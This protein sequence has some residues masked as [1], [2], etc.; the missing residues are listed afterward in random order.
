MPVNPVNVGDD[1]FAPNAYRVLL[2]A[3]RSPERTNV[4][5]GVV[6]RQLQRS[7]ERFATGTPRAGLDALLGGLLLVREGEYRR[8]LIDGGAPALSQ[9]A[10]EVARLGQDGYAAALY[11]MLATQLP[12]GP[13]RAQVE[14]HLRAI[15]DFGRAT[16]S[17]GSIQ[18]AATAARVSVQRALLEATP[19]ALNAGR[20]RLVTWIRRALEASSSEQPP[21]TNVERDEAFETYRALRGGT[22]ALVALYIRHGDP[23][24]VLTAIDEA[25][26]DRMIPPE[27]RNYLERAAEHEPEAW[28]ALYRVFQQASES[29]GS[30]AVIDPELMGAAAFGAAIELFRIQPSSLDAAMP[31]SI[32][33]I[34]YGMAEVA[35]LV[36]SGAVNRSSPPEHVSAALETVLR[37]IVAEDSVGQTDAARR[38]FAAAEK[39]MALGESSAFAGRVTPGPARLRYVMAA[40]ETRHAELGRALPLLRSA[41]AAEPTAEAYSMIASIERQQRHTD[42]ALE[43]LDRVIALSRKENDAGSEADA[44][45]QRFEVLRDEGRLDDAAKALDVALVRV[46]EA[47]RA[48]HPG[49]TQARVER[50]L[51]RVLEHYGEQAAIHRATLRA[52]EA[53][54]GDVRQV[55]ATVLDVSRRSLTLGDL[56]S[57]RSAAQR[58]LA[59]GLPPEEIVYVALWLQ[60]LERRLNVP[61]DGTVEEAYATIDEASGWPSKLRAWGRGKL[62]DRDLVNAAQDASQRTE[63]AFYVAMNQPNVP[64]KNALRDV[65]ASSAIELMEVTIARDLVAAR[66]QYKLPPA[67]AVP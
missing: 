62:T 55:A 15:D 38:T 13:E 44:L 41:V 48:G 60:L 58:A 8:E 17:G 30:I 1:D 34:K 6:R 40:I 45:V 25:D 51:A 29:N 54:D 5:I 12:Q 39:L 31:L 20:D 14:G 9:S 56:Q 67:V 46:I 32:E 43:A 21:R 50:L 3:A 7:R 59:A 49:P 23:Q 47:Q 42:A 53:S 63:A 35:S 61:S 65:A 33:L 19:E 4:L 57:A 18:V 11:S 24:G 52:F 36:V 64:P 66:R 16:Q 27:L 22:I 2:E 10:N 28:A 37:A 26:L